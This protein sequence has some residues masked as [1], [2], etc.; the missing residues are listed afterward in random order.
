V[1]SAHFYAINNIMISLCCNDTKIRSGTAFDKFIAVSDAKGM[2]IIVRKFRNSKIAAWLVALV[3]IFSIIPMQ[4]VQATTINTGKGPVVI[5]EAYGG[6][7]NTG[8]IYKNDFIVLKNIS[9]TEVDLTGWS[10]QY[11]S[12]KVT[13]V[14]NSVF[15][16]NGKIKPGAYY[17][18]E[19][20]A[21]TTDTSLPAIPVSDVNANFSM[22]ATDF[23]LALCKDQTKIAIANVPD[24]FL[25]TYPNV[26]DY[27]GVG[28]ASAFLGTAAAPAVSNST[29]IIRASIPNPYTGNNS[30]DFVTHTPDLTYVTL[31]VIYDPVTDVM[32]EGSITLDLVY[33]KADKDVVTTIGQVAYKYA[34]NSILLQDVINGEIVGL[35]IY[36]YTNFSKYV[37]GDIVKVTGTI[38]PYGGVQ[39][40]KPTSLPTVIGTDTPFAPQVLTALELS[41]STSEYLSEF[42]LIKDATLGAWSEKG[43]TLLTD[44]TGNINIF[45]PVA[46]PAGFTLTTKIS[47]KAAMSAFTDKDN[48]T[49]KQLRVG[50]TSDYI[51]TS[52]VDKPTITLPAFLPAK[53][54]HD[55]V[56]SIDVTDNAGVKE[57]T[58]TYVVAGV[59][60]APVTLVK[61]E[62]TGK[63]QTTIPGNMVTTDKMALKFIAE[64]IFGNL[65][66]AAAD[67]LVEN[68]P[69]VLNVLPVANSSTNTEKMPEFKVAFENA[70][71]NSKVELTINGGTP[72]AMTVTGNIATY[73]PTTAMVDGKVN[74]KVIITRGDGIQSD[75]YEWTFTVG[76]PTYK[77]YFGQLH[78]HTNYSDGSGTP[79][80]ALAY[81]DK[82]ENLDFLALTDHSNY[83]DSTTNLATFDNSN[84]GTVSSV[85]PAMSKWAYYK[86]LF[87]NYTSDDFLAIYGYEMTWSG[88]YGHINTFNSNGIVSRNNPTL[89]AKNGLGLKAYYELLKTQTSTFSQF[90]HPGTTFG[91]FDDFAYNDPAID[92]EINLIEVG[93]GEGP[94]GASGY[95]PSYQYYT[96]ALDKGWHLAPSNGQDNHKGNWG[97]ANTTRTV[98]LADTLTMDSVSEAIENMLVYSTEDN[99]FEID[100]TVN[101]YPMGSTLKNAPTE[102]NLMVNLNDP[103]SADVIGKVSVIVNGG[104]VAYTKTLNVN[105]GKVEVTIPNDYSYYYIMVEQGDGDIAVTAPVWTKEVTQVGITSITKNTSMDVIGET[106][107]FS[108]KLYNFEDTD[109]VLDK[110]VYSVDGEVIKT[111]CP[112]LVK[113]AKGTEKSITYDFIP[114]KVGKQTLTVNI[115]ATLGGVKMAFTKSIIL[116]VYDNSSIVDILID[117][118]HDNFYIAGDYKGNDT[119][120]TSIAGG[121]G[122]RVKRITTPITAEMLE[123]TELLVLTVPYKGFN[124]PLN[125]YTADEILAIKDYADKGGNI[126]LTSKSDRGNPTDETMKAAT[127]SNTILTAIGAKARIAD[128]IVVD[129]EKKSNEAYRIKFIDAE[130][131]NEDS[132]FGK[133]IITGT[134]MTFSS[135]NA[136]PVIANGATEVVR[137]YAS[138]W[139]AN[140]TKNFTGSA[141]VPVYETD[142]VV[143]P[144]D[145]VSLV[146][147]EILSG[148]GFLITSGVTFFS[149]F[150]VTAE[151]LI[152]ESSRNANFM[153]FSN[154]IDEIKGDPVITS[155]KEV[156]AAKEGI[157][158]T[159]MGTLTSNASG[160]DRSTAFFDSGYIQDET[161]GINIFPIAGNYQAGQKV[162]I[163][164]RTSSYQGERQLNIDSIEYVEETINPISPKLM[165]TKE[166]VENLGLLVQVEGI[167]KDIKIDL[168]VVQSIL[169]EDESG[170]SVRVFIDGYIG[171]EVKMPDIKVGDT[172]NAIGLSSIDPEGPRIRVR[173]RNEITLV[174][175]PVVDKSVL[176]AKIEVA[177][178]TSTAGMTQ[179]TIKNLEKTIKEAELIL[180]NKDATKTEVEQAIIALDQAIKG[181]VESEKY[182]TLVDEATKISVVIPIAA[183]DKKPLLVVKKVSYPV[184]GFNTYAY[185]I[186]FTIDGVKVQPKT[187]V[188]LSIPILDLKT[189]RLYL[190]HEKSNKKLENLKYTLVGRNVEIETKDFSI[191][192][193]A[194]GAGTLPAAGSSS[195]TL[196][197]AIGIAMLLGGVLFLKRQLKVNKKN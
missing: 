172:V 55:Y 147:E 88:Q 72:I 177:K 27:L 151:M 101:N 57:V 125:N 58:M 112:D 85:N 100:Y 163:T 190:L 194:S 124:L 26:V 5:Y 164:G 76:E 21:G 52:D 74:A 16:L 185:D 104:I 78:A 90:N 166:V 22:G 103:D 47:L 148:G 19:C 188:T 175:K 10:I 12:A 20:A 145:E 117:A 93:N 178:N 113:V 71:T 141:Y 108:T 191:Y 165:T 56:V 4:K 180:D 176:I 79:E 92:N 121:K 95:F 155:I 51:I 53:A 183:F 171:A 33:G 60:S 28:N 192:I 42:V 77:F 96:Q 120:F 63:Y 114:T 89:A 130:N 195:V 129:N 23:R 111:E 139:G 73:K 168:G 105:S 39:Q 86:S 107:T 127:I 98:V 14:F 18:I 35:Q 140:Y 50:A 87:N 157:Q 158:F 84:S 94:V 68:K 110:V 3:F 160:F 181:L 135:Y 37:V 48:I 144:K 149:N 36:D 99:N 197:Y 118:A 170:Q 137:G 187:K 30:V 66:T 49:T 34:G 82:V 7:G 109:L 15:N 159:I 31:P 102:I 59:E 38:S 136:G 8:A 196:I 83:F 126:L 9:R 106:S 184:E 24:N 91:T 62:T 115:E 152:E 97:S 132:I 80:Q 45:R 61:D 174:V 29:S 153:I 40:V 142:L 156:Q 182:Y 143:V 65:N 70:G 2:E 11:A 1:Q 17:L 119:Y 186:S 75:P 67:V 116:N 6:G 189:E 44:S 64:D 154:I 69:Q 173:D 167:V 13:S 131:Y 81:A 169:L 179:D 162:M 133:G 25:E 193:L 138:T 128:G 46:F 150:E 123:E 41:T 54:L 161:G 122:A 32:A 43:N 146:T 134:D